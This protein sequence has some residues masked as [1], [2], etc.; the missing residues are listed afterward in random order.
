MHAHQAIR[1]KTVAQKPSLPAARS[2]DTRGVR[3]KE[4]LLPSSANVRYFFQ[5][6]ELESRHRCATDPI[7]SIKVYNIKNLICQ[8]NQPA[9]FYLTDGPI[10]IP[11]DT[12]LPPNRIL[13]P[14]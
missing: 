13:I 7:L 4:P 2:A 10:V 5:P 11:P 1:A 6:G 9:L 8:R 14:K 3:L 12:E